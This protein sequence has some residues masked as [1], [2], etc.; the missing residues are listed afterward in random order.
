MPPEGV[1][2]RHLQAFPGNAGSFPSSSYFASYLSSMPDEVPRHSGMFSRN[3]SN[4]DAVFLY[5]HGKSVYS[6]N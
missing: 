1:G 2:A 6:A 4:G 5:R 3:V